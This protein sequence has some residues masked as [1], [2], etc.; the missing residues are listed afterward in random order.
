M[1]IKVGRIYWIKPKA[2]PF[3]NSKVRPAI[4]LCKYDSGKTIFIHLGSSEYSEPTSK[5]CT[6]LLWKVLDES[7]FRPGREVVQTFIHLD[8]S[9]PEWNTSVVKPHIARGGGFIDI[10]LKV[11]SQIRQM[12]FKRLR[13]LEAKRFRKAK[14]MLFIGDKKDCE[15]QLLMIKDSNPI[16]HKGLKVQDWINEHIKKFEDS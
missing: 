4:A 6:H 10:D 5:A 14:L 2:I 7:T 13:E 16:K 11:V 3:E 8:A 12:Y 15:K 9:K 1:F